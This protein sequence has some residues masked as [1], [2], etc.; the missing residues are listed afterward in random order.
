M[1]DQR[2]SHLAN[3][4][5][6]LLEDLDRTRQDVL[7]PADLN[8][9]LRQ[10][11]RNQQSILSAL[12]NIG[13]T[14]NDRPASAPALQAS[15]PLISIQPKPATETDDDLPPADPELTLDSDE[16]ASLVGDL[17]HTKHKNGSGQQTRPETKTNG[18]VRAPAVHTSETPE[19]D[20]A[21]S[22]KRV[23]P[24]TLAKVFVE[25]FDNQDRDFEKGLV[26]LNRWVSAGTGG[27]PFQMR[28]DWA[29][30][31]LKGASPAG[32]R[33]YEEQ[34]MKRMGFGR[35]VGRLELPGLVGDI[36][37]YERM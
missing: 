17:K 36:V 8:R 9:T 31:N 1:S 14:P 20:D 13:I 15:A 33:N 18:R 30:L 7:A 16:L 19:G 12:A 10:I 32:V 27:T 3:R 6:D 24:P 29:Y 22:E 5:R 23:V 4:T 34:L 37:V 21:L 2:L 25:R 11:L 35:R 26:K 28:D